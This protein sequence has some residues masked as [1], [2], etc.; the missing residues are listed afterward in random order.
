MLSINMHDGISCQRSRWNLACG[1]RIL[2]YSQCAWELPASEGKGTTSWDYVLGLCKGLAV[3]CFPVA[4]WIEKDKIR[5][6]LILLPSDS[7]L[8]AKYL[9]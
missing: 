8:L 9:K 3:K 7:V 5:F 2:L 1:Q 6:S 4:Q